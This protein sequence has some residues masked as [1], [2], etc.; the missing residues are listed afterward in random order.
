MNDDDD[1]DDDDEYLRTATL[2][3][4]HWKMALQTA[5]TPVHNCANLVF[6]EMAP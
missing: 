6:T 5:I 2:R 3:Y 1:D 4:R